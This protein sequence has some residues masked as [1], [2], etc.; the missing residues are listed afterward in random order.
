MTTLKIL[1]AAVFAVL[2]GSCHVTQH[3]TERDIA[4]GENDIGGV[5]TSAN[6]AEAGVWVIAET[7]DL[8]TKLAKI[9]VTD[10][11][12]R[13]VIPDLPKGTYD[14][15][16]RGYGLIDSGKV[17]SAPGRIVDLRAIVALN[18]A[19]AAE[20]F[21]AIYWYSM[22]EIPDKSAFSAAGGKGIAKVGTQ[23]EWLNVVKTNGCV[24]CHQMG[25]KATR[26]I[27]QTFAHM[28]PEAAWSTRIM[29]GQAMTNM[30]NAIARVD[31]P[32]A[33]RLFA[34]WTDRIARG[35]LPAT[36]PPRPQGVERNV[37]LTVW[38]WSNPTAYLHDEVSTDKRKPTVNANGPLFGATEES[39]DLIPVLDPAR[40]AATEIKHPVRD[41]QTPSSRANPLSESPY[42]GKDPIWDSQTTTHNPMYDE[43]ARVWFTARVRHPDNP[44]FCRKG[45]AH[46][47]AKVFPMERANRHLSMYDPKSGRFTL[48]STCYSTHH[49]VFAEDSNHTLWTSGGGPVVGWLNRRLFEET[50]D[51]ERA[52]G[53]TPLVLDTN[54]NGKRDDYVEPNQPVDPNKDKRI[55]TGFY[56]VA[57]SPVDGSIWGSSLGFPGSVVRVNPGPDPTHTALTEVYELP[58]AMN[59]YGVRGM[60]IDR[61]GVV[62]SSLAS[63]HLASFD[64]KRCKGPLNGPQATGR[65]CPEGWTLYPLPGPQFENVKDS[66][67]AESSYYTWVDQFDT[68]GLG[69]NVPI[70]TGNLNDGLLALVGDKFVTLRVPYPMGFYTKWMDGRIDDPNGGWKGRGLWT[71]TSTRAPFHMEG[72]KGTR[73]KVVK[74]QL[75]P[76]P[77][78]R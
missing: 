16:V 62:W 24:T 8:P 58:L 38:D 39:T 40:H 20:Y 19:A 36:R 4:I 28:S 45:S 50:G 69:R 74:F 42:W 61:N 10:E 59:G 71:T 57:V 49:L 37:V 70:A 34:N 26:T 41:P 27:P 18:E 66:G 30:V 3:A 2:L 12:G 43:Q 14:V 60:D 54:G 63:G 33:L 75:R 44:A 1:A 67:S 23:A 48:I 73:P 6:G 29:A 64:R 68:L 47:S 21:P 35:D 46:P 53:W 7:Q 78:A 17:R 65:H 9:V 31:A 52:Q 72:G 13:Y 32:H 11:R 77:L 51:E 76:D 25:N 22:L 5:V 56:G 15:W 55:A